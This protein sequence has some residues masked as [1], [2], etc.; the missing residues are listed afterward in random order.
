MTPALVGGEA[1]L[2]EVVAAVLVGQDRADEV[3]DKEARAMLGSISSAR[4]SWCR[5]KPSSQIGFLS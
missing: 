1:M 3:A 2:L 4:R 5:V